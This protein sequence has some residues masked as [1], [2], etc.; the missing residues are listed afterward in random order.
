M[1]NEGSVETLG[2][3]ELIPGRQTQRLHKGNILHLLLKEYSIHLWRLF[4]T[5]LINL[6]PSSSTIHQGGF[7]IYSE[8][9]PS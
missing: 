6:S 2:G 5:L 8:V 4:L 9:V 1:P 3:M 7:A